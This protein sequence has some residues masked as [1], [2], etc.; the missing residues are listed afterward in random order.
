M[1]PLGAEIL[2]P[3]H[4][5]PLIGKEIIRDTMIVYR[6]GIQ[7]VHDQTVRLMNKGG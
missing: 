5:R 6:D 1:I 2:V 7:F 4:G 3:Q